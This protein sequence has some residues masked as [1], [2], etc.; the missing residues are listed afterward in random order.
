MPPG[1]SRGS[2]SDSMRSAQSGG[3]ERLLHVFS[4]G[5]ES[6]TLEGWTEPC[7]ELLCLRLCRSDNATYEVL[8]ESV[9]DKCL[10]RGQWHHLA[11]NVT[12][13]MHNKRTVVEVTI[14]IDGCK[15]VK[16]Q[17]SFGG[18]LLRKSRPSCFLLGHSTAAKSNC[19]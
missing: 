10:P 19:R 1:S 3:S 13:R 12:D 9:I 17:L 11:I 8:A 6:L 16:V 5:G 7:S 15:E 2:L 14:I 4:V 18:L